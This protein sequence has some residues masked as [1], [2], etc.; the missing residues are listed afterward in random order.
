[1]QHWKAA[2]L[3][4]AG[5]ASLVSCKPEEVLSECFPAVV[6]DQGCGTVLAILDPRA[7][8]VVD[9]QPSHDTVYVNTFDLHPIYQVAGKKTVHHHRSRQRQ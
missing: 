2:L 1:M 8:Q 7:A 4:S 9:T 6:L 5:L 3:L